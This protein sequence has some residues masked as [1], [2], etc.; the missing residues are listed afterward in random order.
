MGTLTNEMTR[1]QLAAIRAH[2]LK[3]GWIDKPKAFALCDC[4]RLGARV[5]DLRHDPVA[6]MNIVTDYKTK[7]N[8]MGHTVRYAVY[9]LVGKEDNDGI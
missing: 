9:R 8:R 2:L 7:K 5:W 4:D 6:P 3:H 1:S